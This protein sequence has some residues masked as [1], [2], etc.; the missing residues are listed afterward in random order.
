MEKMGDEENISNFNTKKHTIQNDSYTLKQFIEI[1][2]RNFLIKKLNEN[3]TLQ[4][5][6]DKL[7]INI[8]TLVR[9]MNK[10]KISKNYTE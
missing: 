8:S 7:D 1:E 5:C 9:K 10:Y 4:E 2:E 3:R 6:A